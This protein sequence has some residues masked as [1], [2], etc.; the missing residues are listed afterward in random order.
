[1]DA[2]ELR[3]EKFLKKQREGKG[4]LNSYDIQESN[5]ISNNFKK[6]ENSSDLNQTKS[7]EIQNDNNDLIKRQVIKTN[8]DKEENK[9]IEELHSTNVT[10]KKD[11]KKIYEESKKRDK[12]KEIL[13]NI[14]NLILI[15]LSI[16]ITIRGIIFN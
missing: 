4:N 11:L 15:S 3:R 13:N 16:A 14:R 2:A 10:K 1:M 12:T 7:N 5:I 9:V 8:Q 6:V